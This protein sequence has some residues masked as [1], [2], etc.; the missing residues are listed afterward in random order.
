MSTHSNELLRT[1]FCEA[2]SLV[3]SRPLTTSPAIGDICL[4]MRMVPVLSVTKESPAPACAGCCSVATHS[5]SFGCCSVAT[6]SASF[7]ST[8]HTKLTDRGCK[9]PFV[10]R[11]VDVSFSP[12][13]NR[14]RA[15]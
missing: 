11:V 13:S 3:N 12:L 4:G 7:G 8:N 9:E 14:V 1:S 15:D 5:A 6:H 2:E 10:F